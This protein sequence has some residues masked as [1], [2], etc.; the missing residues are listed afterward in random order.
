MGNWLPLP[1][2]VADVV[3]SLLCG[4]QATTANLTRLLLFDA[5]T[6]RIREAADDPVRQREFHEAYSNYTGIAP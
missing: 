4:K 3:I 5:A 1:S 6:A 2:A